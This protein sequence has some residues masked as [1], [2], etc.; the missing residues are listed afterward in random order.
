MP[1]R[2]FIL[3]L[4]SAL[5]DLQVSARSTRPRFDASRTA[6]AIKQ[7]APWLSPRTVEN[8]DPKDFLDLPRNEQ[9]ALQRAVEDFRELAGTTPDDEAPTDEQY[10][11]GLKLLRTICDVVRKPILEDWSSAVESLIA[12]AER[13]SKKHDWPTKREAKQVEESLLGAY[14]VPQLLLFADGVTF[15]V[16]PIARFA[17]GAEGVAEL[18]V[19][20]SYNY[21]VIPRK[22]AGWYIVAA[23]H[24][25]ASSNKLE[26]L[27]EDSFLRAVAWLKL[28]K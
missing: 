17:A 10:D 19:V 16:D 5:G 28:Q 13:W 27:N 26:S 21:L 2:K 9:E 6:T 15:L 4:L 25:H 23:E 12:D 18:A 14:E 11:Q 3:D 22:S 1:K 7:A 8:F 20:P 24:P